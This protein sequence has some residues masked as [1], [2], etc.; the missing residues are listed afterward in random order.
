MRKPYIVLV[1]YQGAELAHEIQL[2]FNREATVVSELYNRLLPPPNIKYLQK[3]HIDLTNKKSEHTY[4]SP[5]SPL[6]SFFNICCMVKYYD[7]DRY[8]SLD[9]KQQQR[10]I[11]DQI[12]LNIEE[13][14]KQ[15]GWD[16][17]PFQE[18]YHKVLDANF[19]NIFVG[20]KVSSKDRKHKAAIELNTDVTGARISILFFDKKETLIQRNLIKVAKPQ[21]FFF[22]RLIGSFHWIDNQQF[23]LSDI[24]DE[25]H[26]TASLGSDQIQLSFTPEGRSEDTLLK[27]LKILDADTSQKETLRLLDLQMNN[28]RNNF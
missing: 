25:I 20:K 21:S 10:E 2:Q 23:R 22:S 17:T 1:S 13:A 3:I 11:L 5:P 26:F 18:A 12:Q 24:Q 19:V 27:E 9:Q 4:I 15:Y 8:F 6:D 28:F 16:M 7:F 14:A